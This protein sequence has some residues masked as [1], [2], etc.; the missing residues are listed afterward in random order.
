MLVFI[1]RN[2]TLFK[3]IHVSCISLSMFWFRNSSL[4][5]LISDKW[6]K[7]CCH[8]DDL[9]SFFIRFSFENDLSPPLF[10]HVKQRYIRTQNI[11]PMF[12]KSDVKFLSWIKRC[13][14]VSFDSSP[15]FSSTHKLTKLEKW[16]NSLPT[17]CSSTLLELITASFS[18]TIRMPSVFAASLRSSER[19]P[20]RLLSIL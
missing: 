1:T 6:F 7:R 18:P 9:T 17:E 20:K 13:I 3:Q 12:G 19:K 5:I 16:S 15:C 8:S 14:N 11:I 4:A 2:T 10:E